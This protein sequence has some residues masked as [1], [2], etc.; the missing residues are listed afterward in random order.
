MEVNKEVIS[1]NV[2]NM[3]SALSEFVDADVP[4]YMP[5]MTASSVQFQIAS[6]MLVQSNQRTQQLLSLTR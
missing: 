3:Q 1:S 4:E 2:N 5:K 6:A